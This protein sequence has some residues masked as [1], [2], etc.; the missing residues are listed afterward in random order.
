MLDDLIAHADS[1]SPGALR[2][3][4]AI[5][6]H[7][8]RFDDE[9]KLEFLTPAPE[10]L[11]ARAGLSPDRGDEAF[12]LLSKVIRDATD[13][14]LL[15]F[16]NMED[17]IRNVAEAHAAAIAAGEKLGRS[18]GY[19]LLMDLRDDAGDPGHIRTTHTYETPEGLHRLREILAKFVER[20]DDGSHERDRRAMG[21]TPDGE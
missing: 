2:L 4:L 11:L 14:T 16:Q 6:R 21:E 19:F 10:E 15:D 3:A 9:G 20:I 5:M 8:H 12:G 13:V 18:D 7:S 1:L 17:A